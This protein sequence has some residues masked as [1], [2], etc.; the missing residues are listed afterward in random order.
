MDKT[1]NDLQ[2]GRILFMTTYM[3]SLSLLFLAGFASQFTFPVQNLSF[4]SALTGLLFFDR[5]IAES[6][7]ITVSI[8][9]LINGKIFLRL[10]AYVLLALFLL[11]NSVQLMSIIQGGEFLSRLAIDNINHINILLHA[12]SLVIPAAALAALLIP[13]AVIHFFRLGPSSGKSLLHAV[14]PLIL[15]GIFFSQSHWWIPEAIAEERQ[16]TFIAN[17]IRHTSPSLALYRTLFPDNPEFFS[18][19]LSRQ[20]INRLKQFG[21]ILDAEKPYPLIKYSIYQGDLPFKQ[22][23]NTAAVPNIIVFF[24]EGISARSLSVYGSKYQ[25]ITPNLDD[26]ADHSMVVNNYFNHTAATYRGLHGQ[27]CSLYP[28]FGG[29]GGWYP[30]YKT[31]NKIKYLS[32]AKLLNQAGYQTIFLDSHLKDAAYVDDMMRKFDF[33]E[34]LT[35]EDLSKD[36]LAGA[37]PG[38][39]DALSDTQLYQSL[40]GLLK[41]KTTGKDGQQPFFIGLYNYGTHSWVNSSDDEVHFADGWNPSLNTIHNLDAAFGMFWSYFQQSPYAQNTLVIFT[42][43][44]CHYPTQPFVAEIDDPNY[45]RIF[46]D[47]IPLIIHD[48]QRELP[49]HFDAQNSTSLDFTPTLLHLLKFKNQPNPFLGRSIF[50]QNKRSAHLGVTVI[51]PDIFIIDDKKIHNEKNSKQYRQDLQLI[52][53]FIKIIHSLELSDKLWLEQSDS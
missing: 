28:M 6:V 5:F 33:K 11:I 50:S 7:F 25:D 37:T 14:I 23:N 45:Q 49:A 36:F 9:L 43:D 24:S 46:V 1:T 26:F 48:P 21:F 47:R 42:T 19:K 38:Q 39:G 16:D 20:E 10:I 31:L 18:E 17:N 35:A 52:K 53:K 44:H 29:N 40:I 32:L 12:Q 34:V 8:L 41:E 27:L 13:E 3:V 22:K 51:E 30:N 2:P 4:S 15:L